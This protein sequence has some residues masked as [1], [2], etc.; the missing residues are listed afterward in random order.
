MT[1]IKIAVNKG[2][3]NIVHDF[4]VH[5]HYY[6][7]EEDVRWRLLREIENV[8]AL[9]GSDHIPFLKGVTSVI[10]TEY[11]TPFRCSMSERQFKLLDVANTKGQRGHFD[12]AILNENA[13][14]QC[15]FEILRSQYYK[16]LCEN[17]KSGKV[18]LPLLDYAIELKLFRDLAHP[19]RTESAKQQAEYAAQ[20]VLKLE[21]TVQPN[22]Y[23]PK[24]FA[25][26]GIV[27]LFDNSELTFTSNVEIARDKFWERFI[28]L[29]DWNSL[30]SKLSCIWVSPYKKVEFQG[31]RTFE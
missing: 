23:Y 24:P 29:I 6:F 2:I 19:N 5:P 9:D 20:A 26:R 1:D 17:L 11:P 10:H 28:E 12:I 21:A 30:S 13:A 27:L 15:E 31:K 7:T 25:N 14:S 22:E 3:G 18:P 8:L 4:Q 16:T